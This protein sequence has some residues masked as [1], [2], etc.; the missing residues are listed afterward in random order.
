MEQNDMQN[1]KQ[2]EQQATAKAGGTGAHIAA[3]YFTGGA[4]EKVR[5][6]P[7][8]GKVAKGAEKAIGNAVASSPI[9][10]RLGKTAKKLDES[11]TIDNI[12]NA[13]SMAAGGHNKDDVNA[14]K[15]RATNESQ[16]SDR[17]GGLRN[18][19][20]RDE[21]EL[22]SNNKESNKPD[23]KSNENDAGKTSNG[24]KTK[25][26][27][28][29]DISDDEEKKGILDVKGN[30]AKKI[31]LI[32]I[33]II[34]GLGAVT[35]F[36]FMILLIYM[37]DIVYGSLASFF[38]ISEVT[39]ENEESDGLMDSVK[40]TIN[41]ETG[42]EYDE[43]ELIQHLKDNNVCEKSGIFT[44]IRDW[45]DRL[46]GSY[47]SYCGLYRH[48][49]KYMEKKEKK[50][51][52]TLDKGIILATLYYGYTNQ[53]D[54]YDYKNIPADQ[55]M[56]DAYSFYASLEEILA[57][58]KVLTIENVEAIIDNTI[59]NESYDY[60]EWEVRNVT[61]KYGNVIKS[62]GYCTK[63][64]TD[65]V[66]YSS[67]KWKIM[68]RY[69]EE[70]ATLYEKDLKYGN[71]FGA[72]SEECKEGMSDAELLEIVRS[73]GGG[74]P[75]L[76]ESVHEA[77][78]FYKN[79]RFVPDLGVFNQ[80]ADPDSNNEVHINPYTFVDPEFLQFLIEYYHG[81]D[82]DE[83]KKVRAI[84][85][86]DAYQG[87]TFILDYRYGF[88]YVNFPAFKQ[89]I[90]DPNIELEY[91]EKITPK[92]IEQDIQF[93]MEKK[94]DVNAALLLPDLDSNDYT[95]LGDYV[96]GQNC[97]GY[98]TAAPD[99]IQ[100]KVT[101]CDG[102]PI[103]TTSFKDYIM[104]V[105]YGEVSNSGDNYVLSQMVASISY[106]LHRRNNYTK[107][108]TI[109]MKS[110]NCDQV[111]C[112]MNEG[113]YSQK[114][115]LSCGSFKCT[116]YYPGKGTYHGKASQ[117]LIDKYSNY[118]ET[119]KDYLIVS[120]GKVHSVHYVSSIQL[121]WKSKAQQGEH[122]TQ[123]LQETY[124]SEGAQVI[125]CS[126]AGDG[127]SGVA[128]ATA[129]S[130][131]SST[132]PERAPDKGKFTGFAYNDAPEGRAITMDPAWKSANL[133]TINTNC[134]SG[135][136]NESYLINKNAVS[137]FSQAYQNMC[138]LLTTGVTLSDGTHCQYNASQYQ[139]GGTFVERKTN[140]GGYSLHAYG[141]AQDW[142]YTMAINV[143]G[144]TYKPYEYQG[145]GYKANY[146]RFVSALGKEEHCTN[147]NYILWKYAFE[148]AGFNW[149]G[150]WSASYW[151]GMHFEVKY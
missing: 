85:N 20:N 102:S 84:L 143:N 97:E 142:N 64:R 55:E 94:P 115:A 32:K 48:I 62:I 44:R 19:R 104:G 110:G 80:D 73:A 35:I 138:K 42:E 9:G 96:I 28:R 100:V 108:N 130:T 89:S 140:S 144:V 133:T 54:F 50:Y 25:S 127:S 117:S 49:F 120:N 63:Q 151:D 61:D 22:E 51:A 4:Y 6:A 148:P 18:R 86:S 65:Y 128:S 78:D 135:G 40:Y 113:C 123:I 98:L 146:D 111:Y 23:N 77:N 60:Y 43:D 1:E 8:V 124:G 17:F 95:L 145:A 103:R 101:D 109:T 131:P 68:M 82:K 126:S 66:H 88:A 36:A 52:I 149:G 2:L 67:F 69:G 137:N 46:D 93:I 37:Y 30:L 24:G 87:N 99:S 34:V 116:S 90:E 29:T 91:D 16:H 13:T 47:N 79:R 39:V 119:A 106:A 56:T 38:G 147:I 58:G 76:D 7:V 10:K 15:N 134:S 12:N 125:Q 150:N 118:Y 33:A 59:L 112:P 129:G 3:D 122:F 121:G 74:E 26:T 45:F 75:E 105:A 83:E 31:Q 107:G 114:A 53:Q 139:N 14:L 136:W 41:P 70:A 11:G 71:S 141:I 81:K 27:N 92:Q 72:S 132:Y 5:N 57:E 21:D